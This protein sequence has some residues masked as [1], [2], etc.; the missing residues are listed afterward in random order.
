MYELSQTIPDAKVLLAME[1]E[2]LGAK[3][4]FVLR[5][6]SN[7]MTRSQSFLCSSLLGELWPQTSLPGQQPP[8]PWNLQNQI[9]LALG[10]LGHG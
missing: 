9:N 1:P 8:Y 3:I 4:L 5:K 2:E 7:N 6:R 10:R